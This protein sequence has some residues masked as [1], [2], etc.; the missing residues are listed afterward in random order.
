MEAAI[1]GSFA[2]KISAVL[3]LSFAPWI[4]LSTPCGTGKSRPEDIQLSLI[5][6]RCTKPWTVCWLFQQTKAEKFQC[7]Q[8]IPSVASL[9]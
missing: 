6:V 1:A 8:K 4:V 7:K 9:K 2:E 5:L 3:F